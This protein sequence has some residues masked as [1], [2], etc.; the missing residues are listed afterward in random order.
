MGP[1]KIDLKIILVGIVLL[2]DNISAD[3]NYGKVLVINYLNALF[4][5]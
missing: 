3:N 1:F 4:Y 5:L 2:L